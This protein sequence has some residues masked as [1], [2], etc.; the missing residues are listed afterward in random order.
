MGPRKLCRVSSDFPGLAV[1]H[2][3]AAH[4]AVGRPRAH[5][6]GHTPPPTV[7]LLGAGACSGEAD[8]AGVHAGRA[9]SPVTAVQALEGI[10]QPQLWVRER[11]QLL[12][13][14]KIRLL[15]FFPLR[16][17][18]GEH[19]RQGLSCTRREG[20]KQA[21]PRRTKA[22]PAVQCPAHLSGEGCAGGRDPDP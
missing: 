6:G 1:V 14:S 11:P 5:P 7:L 2:H 12:E 4:R 20:E 17:P 10:Y 15:L 13:S 9:S 21:F 3:R 16:R 18:Q 19:R 8:G 22:W